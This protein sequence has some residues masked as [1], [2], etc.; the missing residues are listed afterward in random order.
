M[1]IYIHSSIVAVIVISVGP[2]KTIFSWERFWTSG[3]I[4]ITSS[5]TLKECA[6]MI[7]RGLVIEELR[8]F[9]HFEIFE[10]F[11]RIFEYFEYFDDDDCGMDDVDDNEAIV[12]SHL[13]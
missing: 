11:Y 12:V 8:K 1:D 4:S 6:I 3:N 13:L 10:F 9:K 2:T 5:L 7:R